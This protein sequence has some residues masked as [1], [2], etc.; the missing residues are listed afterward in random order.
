MKE[1]EGTGTRTYD[2]TQV[3]DI[4]GVSP[5]T[6]RRLVRE[7]TAPVHP[8]DGLGSHKFSKALVDLVADGIAEIEAIKA[9]AGIAEAV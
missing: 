4:F 7:G 6:Y 1:K 8:I 9:K 2:T 3:A 5:W